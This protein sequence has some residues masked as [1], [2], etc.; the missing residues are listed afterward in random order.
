MIE[1]GEP[2]G[3]IDRSVLTI[4]Q[5][6]DV[7][8]LALGDSEA[9]L[10]L[11]AVSKLAARLSLAFPPPEIPR[12]DTRPEKPS[13]TKRKGT[14]EK[15]IHLIEAD[16]LHAGQVITLTN[17]GV[18]HRAKITT[19]GDIEIDGET[20]DTPSGAGKHATKRSSDGWQEWKID[21]RPLSDRRWAYRA[22]TFLANDQSYD[23]KTITEK[24]LVAG[25][26]VR[27]AL[28]NGLAPGKRDDD[29]VEAFLGTGNYADSTLQSYRRHLKQ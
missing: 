11:D 27:Y 6:S 23:P 18:T 5:D 1:R 16:L 13:V 8:V 17:R 22:Q 19:E 2:I 10:S 7:V 12:Q 25:R 14:W 26:W 24:R 28:D 9:R 15:I 21:G 3:C 29:A 4:R 20:F